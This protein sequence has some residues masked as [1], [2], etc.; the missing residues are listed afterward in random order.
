MEGRKYNPLDFNFEL[1]FPMKHLVAP[2]QQ[3]S[4]KELRT[5]I[6]VGLKQLK[7]QNVMSFSLFSLNFK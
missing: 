3:A 7:Q 4:A 6:D 2:T 5:A 1:F